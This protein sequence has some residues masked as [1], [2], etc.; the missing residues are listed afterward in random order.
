MA[1]AQLFFSWLK[2]FFKSQIYTFSDKNSPFK[3]QIWLL[4]RPLHLQFIVETM[5]MNSKYFVDF[6]YLHLRVAERVH[7]T[8]I[9]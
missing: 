9:F 1:Q 2:F 6:L 3:P 5:E 4:N 8:P 7:C